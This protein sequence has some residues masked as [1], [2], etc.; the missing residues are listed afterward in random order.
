MIQ[1]SAFGRLS[2]VS[3]PFSEIAR[4]A[5]FVCSRFGARLLDLM[6]DWRGR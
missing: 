1:S 2:L 5:R 6:S 3:M 4:R